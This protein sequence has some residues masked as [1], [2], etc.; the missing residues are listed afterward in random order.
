MRGLAKVLDGQVIRHAE[1]RR[2]GLRWPFPAGLVATLTGAHVDGF[3]RRGK[4]MLMRLAGRPSV[5]IHLGMSGRLVARHRDA[6]LVPSLGPQGA[7]SDAR[8]HNQPPELHEH[9]MLETES[10]WRVGF[11]DPR[12]FGSVDLIAREAEDT[13]RLLAGLGPEPLEPEFTVAVLEA[14]LAGKITPIKAAL[15]DQKV[16]AGLG[17]IYVSEALFRAGISPRRLSATVP[18]ARA[19]RLVPAIKSVLTDAIE[20]GGSTL[21]DYVRVD[22]EVGGFQDRFDVYDRQGQPCRLCPGPKGCPGIVRL[23]QSGRSTFYC[24]RTQR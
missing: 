5:L 15:L 9:L 7:A 17:N 23:V 16:V 20:A 18:G 10:G 4:Y 21:R 1:T 3:R 14:A 6:P 12:R 19:Q 22:G 24:P 2:E 8:G 13:H 11:V